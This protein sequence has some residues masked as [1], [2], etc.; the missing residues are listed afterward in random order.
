MNI[1]SHPYLFRLR[2]RFWRV[3]SRILHV[4]VQWIDSHAACKAAENIVTKMGGE[5]LVDVSPYPSELRFDSHTRT[6]IIRE[7]DAVVRGRFE[8]LGGVVDYSTGID[9]HR[10]F[11]SGYRWS[12]AIHFT[13][14]PIYVNHP[15]ADIKIPWELSRFQH[16]GVLGLAWRL[17][18]NQDYAQCFKQHVNS[19]IKDNPV[20]Q[21]VNWVCSMDVAIRAVNWIAGWQL[22]HDAWESKGAKESFFHVLAQSL[23]RHALHLRRN[24]EWNGPMDPVRGNHFVSDL[25][26][27]LALGSMFYSI[28]RGRAWFEFAHRQL[29]SEIHHQ[30]LDDGVIQERTTGYHRLDAELFLYARTVA[31]SLGRPFGRRYD[32]TLRAMREFIADYTMNDGSYFQFGD[33]DDGR[34]LACGTMASKTHAYLALAQ[35][36]AGTE[37]DSPDLFLLTGDSRVRRCCSDRSIAR[38]RAGFFILKGGGAAAIVRAGPLGLSSGHSH[39]DQLAFTMA[40][41]GLEIFTDHGSFL[42]SMNVAQ[43]NRF[44]GTR[45]HSTLLL[46]GREQNPIQ[47]D[48][49][50]LFLLPDQTQTEVLEQRLEGSLLKIVARH[51]GYE[52]CSDPVLHQR[53]FEMDPA[54]KALEIIDEITGGA[55]ATALEWNFHIHPEAKVTLEGGG[56]VISRDRCN[57]SLRFSTGLGAWRIVDCDHSSGY[58]QKQACHCL[59][60]S[61]LIGDLPASRKAAFRI[62]WEIL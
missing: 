3:C 25:V 2:R 44:R 56:G 31:Q 32:N 20:D 46:E 42:Y 9:W 23:W 27:L 24:L 57:V 50:H 60:T 10:D 43:R 54:G 53:V 11:K 62:Q 7:A 38:P 5:A 13:R 47:P 16:A 59:R 21:G 4:P 12:A 61:A 55:A 51:H 36:L 14:V 15:G 48:L 58:G 22:M 19:W 6:L 30:V 40:V 28:R 45:H 39:N 26:G 18:R 33:Q 52:K 1:F 17:T 49:D 29:Q 8:F 35:G 41:G 34:L 37:C